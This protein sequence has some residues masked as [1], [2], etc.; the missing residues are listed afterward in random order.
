MKC[1]G[2]FPCYKDTATCSYSEPQANERQPNILSTALYRVMTQ[3]VVVISSRRFRWRLIS[4]PETSVRNYHYS[5]CNNPEEHSYYLLR[6]ES[7]KPH[8]LIL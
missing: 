3:R 6:G 5:L 4:C 2:L 7:L 8:N 1:E